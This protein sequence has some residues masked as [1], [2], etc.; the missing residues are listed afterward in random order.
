[1]NARSVENGTY[2]VATPPKRF[3]GI[4]S[5]QRR[6]QETDRPWF[7]KHDNTKGVELEAAVCKQLGR[8]RDSVEGTVKVLGVK[9]LSIYSW[10]KTVL[11]CGL[12][13]A[14]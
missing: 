7:S 10:L 2:V 9:L 1:M 8:L 4:R 6:E 5:I 3:V 12:T 11:P 14:R 13:S